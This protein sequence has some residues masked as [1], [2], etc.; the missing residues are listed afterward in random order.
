MYIIVPIDMVLFNS[1]SIVEINGTSFIYY[2]QVCL[3]QTLSYYRT[4][5]I[6]YLIGSNFLPFSIMLAASAMTVRAL[7][8]SRGRVSDALESREKRHRR[9]K[10]IKFAVNSIVLDLLFVL[11]QTPISLTYFIDIPDQIVY[12]K[13]YLSSAI[14]YFFNYTIPIFTYICSNS[15]F[16][17]ELLRMFGVKIFRKRSTMTHSRVDTK[18]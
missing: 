7:V 6:M 2:S 4:I 9:A 11:F 1:S 17:R 5:N 16:R 8:M 13:F 15:I 3:L 14:L 18:S 12:Y 10:D